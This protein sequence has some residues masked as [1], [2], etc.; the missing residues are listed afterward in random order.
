VA[1]GLTFSGGELS[2]R[3]ANSLDRRWSVFV[4][5]WSLSRVGDGTRRQLLRDLFNLRPFTM[6]RWIPE[7]LATSGRCP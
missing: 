1:T 2:V 3:V 4:D 7:G 5:D 6:V